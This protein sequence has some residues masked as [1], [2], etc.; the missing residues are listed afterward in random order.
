VLAGDKARLQMPSSKKGRK[1]AIRR[2]PVPIPE[3]LA[4][5]LSGRTGPLLLQPD[6]SPWTPRIR[7]WRFAAAVKAAGF[8]DPEKIT[9]YTLRHSSIIRQLLAGTPIRLVAAVHDTSTEQ[10][11]QTYSRYIA[12]HGDEVVRAAMLETS[13][14]IIPLD[15]QR[16]SA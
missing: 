15:G 14:E 10:I 7:G 3:V 1:K 11:E 8:D 12:H 9:L 4:K 13:G 2:V 6:G 16:V 5:R